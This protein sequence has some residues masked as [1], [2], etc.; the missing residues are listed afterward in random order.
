[1]STELVEQFRAALLAGDAATVTRLQQKLAARGDEVITSLDSLLVDESSVLREGAADVLESIGSEAAY[2]K[3]I[4]FALRHLVV[5]STKLPGPGWQRLRRVG[6]PLLPALSRRYDSSLPL[7]VRLIMIFI[8]QQIGDPAGRPLIDRALS[9]TEPRLIEAAGEALGSVDG[10]GAHELL[11]N[12]LN[13]QTQSHGVG[14]VRGFERLGNQ[15]AVRPLFE[16]LV[17]AD[18]TISPM[19]ASA[20]DQVSLRELILDAIDSLAGE[21][22]NGDTD[23]IREW[24]EK[25]HL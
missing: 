3:L 12:M 23:R 18:A 6:K 5:P 2:D 9:E 19:S 17:S 1:L 21:S 16:A 8:A 20:D 15:A 24:L 22:F 7:D 14:A 10:P 25:H 11:V 13:G 4:E